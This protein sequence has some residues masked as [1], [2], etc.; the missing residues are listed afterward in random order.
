MKKQFKI[1]LDEISYGGDNIGRDLIITITPGT[2][3][4]T[5]LKKQLPPGKTASGLD[6]T[7]LKEST[8]EDTKKVTLTVN[9]VEKDKISD[10]GSGVKEITI[11]LKK[12]GPQTTTMEVVVDAKVRNR[13]RDAWACC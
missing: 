6:L 4:T 9:I 10:P 11:D 1:Y 13:S 12:E 8:K 2:A 3:P 5:E 7:V